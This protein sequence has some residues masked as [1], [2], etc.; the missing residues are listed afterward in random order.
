VLELPK[1]LTL[2]AQFRHYV[3]NYSVLRNNKL[4]HSK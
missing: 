4:C 1:V 2:I 3:N